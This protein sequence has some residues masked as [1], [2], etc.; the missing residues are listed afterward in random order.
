MPVHL[1]FGKVSRK[2]RRGGGTKH[3]GMGPD[4]DLGRF[5]QYPHGSSASTTDLSDLDWP[6][7]RKIKIQDHCSRAACLRYVVGA[8]V[9]GR[10]PTRIFGLLKQW[11]FYC[12][13]VFYFRMMY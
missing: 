6:L 12:Y 13:N 7:Y 5:D 9:D 4:Y 2:D 3:I 8:T 1:K 10:D 11:P